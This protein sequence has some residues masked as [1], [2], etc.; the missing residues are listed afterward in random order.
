MKTHLNESINL[1]I[2][3]NEKSADDWELQDLA[4]ELYWWVD[5]F[6]MVFLKDTPVPVPAI[7]FERT[8][9]TSLGYYVKGRN[10][11]GVRENINLNRAHL[12]RPFWTILA[13]LLHEMTHS[14]Q[15][16][17][18]KPSSSW[19]HNKEFRLKLE[20]F[21]IVCNEKGCHIRVGH[22]FIFHLQ[23]HGIVFNHPPHTDGMI[24]A[25]S[26]HRLPGKSKLK[27]WTCGCTNIWVAVR[28]LKAE[29]LKCRNRFERVS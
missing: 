24:K 11:F 12:D 4:T 28:D 5:F 13:T 29:C 16:L 27:K 9:I 18:G 10:A 23:Q 19:F 17:Y 3:E 22:P 26:G 2:R 21:G 7:S 25:L 14:W 15:A 8:K 20:G 6:N 1:A